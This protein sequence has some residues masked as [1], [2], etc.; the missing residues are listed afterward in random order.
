MHEN[1]D[2]TLGGVAI[3]KGR[4]AARFGVTG[5]DLRGGRNDFR[6]I[7]ADELVGALRNRDG[8]FGVFAKREARDA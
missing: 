7:G 3:P 5:E 6:W 2:D 4:N 1:F 8:A